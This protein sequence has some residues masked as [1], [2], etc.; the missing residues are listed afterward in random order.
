MFFILV[1]F[2]QDS[3]LLGKLNVALLKLLL[4]GIEKE[5]DSGFVSHISKNWKYR[6]L[7]QSVSIIK[8]DIVIS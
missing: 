5:L 1:I 8:G 2:F 4:T 6:G 3:L 7:I